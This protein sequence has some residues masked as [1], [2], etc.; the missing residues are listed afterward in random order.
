MNQDLRPLAPTQTEKMREL[1]RLT[2]A[3]SDFVPREA[4][5][6]YLDYPLHTNVGDLLIFLGTM[7]FFR[8]N[9][10]GIPVSFSVR[11]AREKAWA[12][13]EN[14]DVIVCHGGGNFGDIYHSHQALREAAVERFAH[15]PIVIMPQSIHFGSE[16]ELK[17]SAAIFARHDNVTILVRD[18]ASYAVARKHFSDKVIAVPDMAHRLFDGFSPIRDGQS[19]HLGTLK[20]MRRDVEAA[21]D[22]VAGASTLDWKDLLSLN[23]KARIGAFRLQAA[24]ARFLG[25]DAN[26]P[27][28]AY[29]RAVKKT[30]NG[31]CTSLVRYDDWQT[32]RLHGVILGNLLL[33]SVAASDN[34]YR[35][36]ERYSQFWHL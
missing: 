31:L 36:I 24:A 30:I 10:N 29:E 2:D 14:V 5:I 20:L 27:A 34:N 32:S 15:K 11:D 6:G 4:A 9:R 19:Q 18:E 22:Q 21:K 3:V 26:S 16:T 13:L 1:A 12:A 33:K 28:F 25:A 35:K 8:W 23:D 17:R 7:D